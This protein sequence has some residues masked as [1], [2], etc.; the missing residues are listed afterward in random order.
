[1]VANYA[2]TK[3]YDAILAEGAQ[4]ARAAA[5]RVRDRAYLACGLR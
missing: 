5:I 4:R 3:A 2:A 1:M